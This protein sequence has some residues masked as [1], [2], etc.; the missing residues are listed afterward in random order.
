MA[1]QPYISRFAILNGGSGD[2][3]RRV[4]IF[5]RLQNFFSILICSPAPFFPIVRMMIGRTPAAYPP[6]FRGIVADFGM[7]IIIYRVAEGCPGTGVFRIDI[8]I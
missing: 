7:S 4:G 2:R 5:A 1:V 6:L 8:D 3:P